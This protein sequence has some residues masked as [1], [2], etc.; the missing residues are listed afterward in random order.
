[1][2]WDFFFRS[3]LG[4]DE[5]TIGLDNGLYLYNFKSSFSI[6]SWS[7]RD[8]VCKGVSCIFSSALLCAFCFV[9]F[10]FFLVFLSFYLFWASGFSFTFWFSIF[11]QLWLLPFW[12]L[13]SK[14]F[15][16]LVFLLM[17]LC[18]S[19]SFQLFFSPFSHPM[20][21]FRGIF[22]DF[23]LNFSLKSLNLPRNHDKIF[24]TLLERTTRY[25]Y[26][27][28]YKQLHPNQSILV[29]IYSWKLVVITKT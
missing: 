18:S 6:F 22:T 20:G 10:C 14:K 13:P 23:S 24:Y 25:L 12:L 4:T 7:C 8:G 19:G 16:Y 28:I 17:V 3:H 26:I 29:C 5:Q 15:H 9:F 2:L 1:M 27:V 11:R 21:G